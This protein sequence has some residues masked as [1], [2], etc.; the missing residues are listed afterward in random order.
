MSHLRSAKLDPDRIAPIGEHQ[1]TEFPAGTPIGQPAT[2]QGGP[3][4][5]LTGRRKWLLA[6]V[7]AIAVIGIGLAVRHGGKPVAAVAAK[8]EIVSQTVTVIPVERISMTRNLLVTGTL[9]A[10]DDLAIGTETSGLALAE[11]LVDEGD[12]VAAGQMLARFN[13]AVLKADL[14]MKEAAL[15]EAESNMTRADGLIRGGNT[16]A[17]TYDNRRMLVATARA[18]RDQ[19]LA[20]LKQTE[21]RAP[22]AGTITL[23]NAR[24]GAVMGAGATELFRMIRDDRIELVADIPE[25]DL[26]QLQPGQAVSV[27]LDGD[28]DP[29]RSFTGKIRMISPVVDPKTR[30][31]RAK[32]DLP[33]DPALKP[34]RFV[35]GN[36]EIGRAS[37][38]AVPEPAVVYRDQRPVVFVAMPDSKV[39]MR[40]VVTG[41]RQDGKI[42]LTG[43][44]QEG[45]KLVLQGAGYLKGGDSIKIAEQPTTPLRPLPNQQ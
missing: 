21:I 42:A 16:S 43:G 31:G 9:N 36:V 15:S 2:G 27:R 37:Q 5:L 7:A 38:L 35:R 44:V 17:A 34:G 20:R 18:N 32:I 39:E 12:H 10:W 26:L 3:S 29:T 28:T 1:V 14:A 4:G 30:I 6:G 13:D 11:V 40:N 33:R 22:A 45:E 41:P 19:A 25:T 24:I 23:R 8:K